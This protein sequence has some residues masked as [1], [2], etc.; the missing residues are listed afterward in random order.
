MVVYAK[1]D[2]QYTIK[3]EVAEG[4][5]VFQAAEQSG[6]ADLFPEI[7]LKTVPMGV[8][9][10]RVK[11]ATT[12]ILHPGDRVELYRSLIADPKENRRTRAENQRLGRS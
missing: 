12:T 8:F 2:R 5:T 7:D 11:M 9:G 6:L 3:L 1:T 10:V 4:T